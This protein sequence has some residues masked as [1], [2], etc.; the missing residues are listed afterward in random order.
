MTRSTAFGMAV[1]LTAVAGMGVALVLLFVLYSNGYECPATASHGSAVA[2]ENATQ[3]WWP[4]RMICANDGE[5]A[6]FAPSDWGLT[7]MLLLGLVSGLAS[8][9]FW[10]KWARGR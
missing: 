4:V 5:A 2:A 1:S 9:P 8:I 3:S 7:T 10:A 6:G